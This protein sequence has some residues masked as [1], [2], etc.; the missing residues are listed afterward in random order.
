MPGIT[1]DTVIDER[2]RVLNR[3]GS[4][5]MADV[6][7]AE[8]SQLGRRVALKLLYPRF[9]EDH[10]FV[11]RF[12][13]EAS[14]AAG[15]QHPNV[16]QV[17]DR[18]EWDDTYY[19]AMEFLDGRSLKQIIREEGPLAPDRA[20]DIVLQVLRAERFAHKRGI[21]HRDIKPH[22]VIVDE[23]GRANVTDFGIA[24]AGASDM[25]ETGSILG[26]AQY[27]S[28]EQ[29]QGHAVS[30]R[31]DLYSI[32]VILYELL[33]GRLPFQ[34]ESAVSI[35]LKHVTEDPVP[36]RQH[37]PA[38]PP[39]LENVVLWALEKAPERRPT[40]ADAFLAALEDARAHL[41]TGTGA[42]TTAFAAVPVGTNGDSG[43]I[44]PVDPLDEEDPEG[45]E[46]RRRRRRWALIAL[47]VALL[48]GG[49]VAAYVL[50]QPEQLVVPNEVGQTV[51]VAQTRL[52][53]QG[54]QVD[55]IRRTS[56]QKKDE[57]IAQ[58]PNPGEEVEK[59]HTVTLTVSDGPGEGVVPDVAGFSPERAVA[60]VRKAGFRPRLD[61]Q[62]SDSVAAGRAIGTEPVA[63]SQL[64]KGR[65]VKI[66]IS[67]GPQLVTVPDVTGQ[68]R[69]SAHAELAAAGF[70][71]TDAEQESSATPGTVLSQSPSGGTNVS[72]GTT[73][74]LVIA[75]PAPEPAAT[76]KAKAK[77]APAAVDD[78]VSVPN[79]TGQDRDAA[80]S[81]LDGAGLR[82]SVSTKKVD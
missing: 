19:I 46:R 44:H 17:Y 23:E 9:A 69:D 2:Y 76:A 28:P 58:S 51:V 57:V 72:K 59:G 48:V 65:A 79:V 63:G 82:S 29:A 37:N 66:A 68:G 73:V 26:T 39:E 70:P 49:L 42:A 16:V 36:P 31:S 6:Y 11:E 34:A 4:G 45:A 12:R 15:L 47:L 25:T 3:I 21:V 8:D 1:R 24:R 52:Q 5:G 62:S 13:R 38:I 27:L 75:K 14:A 7:C 35:A 41:A 78:R 40:D 60:A 77:P 53:N 61:K 56:V 18:G 32:G 74:R 43:A 50:T 55:V 33:T 64:D 22:N 54:F 30:A 67:T 20:I 10:E 71:V 81:A 80:V